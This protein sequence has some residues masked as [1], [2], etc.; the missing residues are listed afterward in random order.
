MLNIRC[1]LF[2]TNSSSVHSVTLLTEQEFSQW[3][4]GKTVDLLNNKI[5]ASTSEKKYGQYTY[6]E[7]IEYVE[8]LGYNYEFDKVEKDGQTFVLVNYYGYA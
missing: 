6:D 8:R 3:K 2:E 5:A 7:F 4:S 1:G